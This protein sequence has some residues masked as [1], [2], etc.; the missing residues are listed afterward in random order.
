MILSPFL[1]TTFITSMP[2][3]KKK[4]EASKK[5][6]LW[7]ATGCVHVQVQCFTE[8]EWERVNVWEAH[9]C[10]QLFICEIWK[11]LSTQYSYLFSQGTFVCLQSGRKYCFYYCLG[12][13]TL[14]FSPVKARLY[15]RKI[16]LQK[17]S[18]TSS[19]MGVSNPPAS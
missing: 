2:D 1:T 14:F 11:Q 5:Q 12:G 15:V 3:K 8:R 17:S 4:V 19:F 7:L 18:A 10:L 13:L 16:K 9:R 6:K